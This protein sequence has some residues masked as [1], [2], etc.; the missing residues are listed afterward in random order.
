MFC[1][2]GCLGPTQNDCL[3]C[4][5]LYDDGICKE[6]CPPVQKYNSTNHLWV[7]NPDG[8]YA[9]GGTCLRNCPDHL[10]KDA[11]VCMRVCPNNKMAVHGECRDRPLQ[12]NG[13]C[14]KTC[15][16]AEIVNSL[17]VDTYRGCNVI[18]GSLGISSKTFNGNRQYLKM[19]PERLEVF[20]TLRE[21]TGYLYI[22]GYHPEFTNLSYFR[23][24]EVIG[25]QQQTSFPATLH[26]VETSL[27]SLE[28]KSLKQINAGHVVILDNKNLCYADGVNWD[29]ITKNGVVFVSLIAGNRNENECS[30]FMVNCLLME[31]IKP[32]YNF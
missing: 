14:R 24:L 2:G 18:N 27:R 10:L 6:E 30:K 7:P 12:C 13:Q 9:Y 23:N 4:R 17:N 16:G 5:N 31:L 26:I 8:K 21:V 3:A 29:K 11:G 1:V 32:I 22:Q 19:H 28:L 25:G 20:S 15:P